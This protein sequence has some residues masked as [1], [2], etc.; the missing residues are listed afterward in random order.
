MNIFSIG[1]LS[2]YQHQKEGMFN[3]CWS[4]PGQSNFPLNTSSDVTLLLTFY[5]LSSQTTASGTVYE[6]LRRGDRL[7]HFSSLVSDKLDLLFRDCELIRCPRDVMS[8]TISVRWAATLQSTNS[9]MVVCVSSS[10]ESDHVIIAVNEWSV[11]IRITLFK[12]QLHS[13]SRVTQLHNDTITQLQLHSA[14]RVVGEM[15]C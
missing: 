15:C 2:N 1:N 14:S 8:S 11:E 12:L 5:L 6:V 7:I 4:P 13:A 9:I 3:P 10:C